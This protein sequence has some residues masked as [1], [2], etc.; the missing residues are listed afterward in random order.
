MQ[1]NKDRKVIGIIISL[2]LVS[3]VAISGCIHTDMSNVA[4]GVSDNK[5][6]VIVDQ[7][8]RNVT[9]PVNVSRV[10]SLHHHTIDIML[11]LHAGDLL[12]GVQKSW[13]ENLGPNITKIYPRLATLPTPG[14][15]TES[16]LEELISMHP[17][18]VFVP[19]QMP[20]KEI[21]K[22]QNA[23]I[24]T[25]A[26]ACYD[27]EYEEASKLNPN[28]TNPDKAYNEGMKHA[29]S[30]IGETIG[31]EKEAD[32]L[33]A[34]TYKNRDLVI[35][36]TSSIP[37][38]ERVKVYN[39]NPDM[40]TYGTGKYT[41]VMIDRAGGLNVAENIS[42]YKQ[43]SM[44]QVIRWN[45]DII[46]IQDR[47]ANES[48]RI[49]NDTQWAPINA[50][51]NNKIVITPEYV[52]PWGHPTPESMALGELWMGKLLYPDKFSDIDLDAMVSEFYKKFYNSKYFS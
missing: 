47:Y 7:L 1:I 51:K 29:I 8:G 14:D 50:V 30:I 5:T 46:I 36:R 33:I 34:Y 39:A 48:D 44:E 28:L 17:D 15:L 11:E 22:I 26:I 41:G 6:H 43:V 37:E 19:H 25:I 35:N 27:A 31:K 32:D 10:V 45:P 2:L 12:I 18:V 42:G 52:K 24:P 49:K 9:V 21:E 23:G 13:K 16:N 20:Q 3:V 38:N 40:Y 4:P